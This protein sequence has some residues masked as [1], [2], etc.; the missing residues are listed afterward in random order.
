MTESQFEE[1]FSDGWREPSDDAS[2]LAAYILF[3]AGIVIGIFMIYFGI[4]G[5]SDP[6]KVALEMTNKQGQPSPYPVVLCWIAISIGALL[7]VGGAAFLIK[8]AHRWNFR[9]LTAE[10]FVAG[11]MLLGISIIILSFEFLQVPPTTASGHNIFL[12]I[13]P[14]VILIAIG[15]AIFILF[16]FVGLACAYLPK[17]RPARQYVAQIEQRMAIDDKLNDQGD[18]PCPW[19]I[20]C[21]PAVRISAEKVGTRVLRCSRQAYEFAQAG[22]RGIA[23]IKGNILID[24]KPLRG[25][26]R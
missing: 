18:H 2:R 25:F 23:K 17:L 12:A 22:L 24:F 8:E 7:A 3:L 4:R 21:L 10:R 6:A 5:L 26:R 20:G 19:E 13:P 1:M 15:A 11:G 16:L 14:G 9:G